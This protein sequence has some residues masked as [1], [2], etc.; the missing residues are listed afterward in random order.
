MSEPMSSTADTL[1]AQAL[2]LHR[3]GQVAQAQAL[4]Q[5]AL[6]AAP[7]H[8]EALHLL[9]VTW[10]QLGQPAQALPPLEAAVAAAPGHAK[11]LNNLG[12]A[13]R[14]QDRPAE[15]LA[16]FAAAAAAQPDFVDALH[17]QASTL[18]QL[19]RPAEALP[20]L[21][22]LLALAPADP[23]ALAQLGLALAATGQPAEALTALD[24]ALATQPDSPLLLQARA[25]ALV[26]LNRPAEAVVPLTRWIALE[27]EN[28]EAWH[29]R[30]LARAQAGQATLALGDFDRA[31][32]LQPAAARIH[33]NR[34]LACQALNRAE[35]ALAGFRRAAELQPDFAPAWDSMGAMLVN[36]GRTA[37]GLEC[38][39]RALLLAPESL[40]ALVNR[41]IALQRLDRWAE[42]EASY[43]T[44]LD[45]K[46]DHAEAL[47]GRGAMRDAAADPEAA[48]AD[49]R[50]AM[51][52]RPDYAEAEFYASLILLQQGDFAAGWPAYEA[53]RR[54]AFADP[55]LRRASPLWH[56][57]T[58]LV[59]R[60]ILL[61]DE[62]GLGDTFQFCRFAPLL[63]A[64][65]ARVLLEV[66]PP[67]VGVLRSLGP[68]VTVYGGGQIGQPHDLH[69]SL[70]SVPYA[71]GITPETVPAPIPYLHADPERVAHWARHIGT[72][73]LRIGICWQGS[74]GPL[75]MGRSIPL[76]EFLPLAQLPG[77]RLISL[78]KG[79][80]EAQLARLP[81]GM[82]VESL[83]ADFD[84]PGHAFRDTAAVMQVC[85][86]VITCDTAIGHL[87]GALGVPTWVVVKHV[88]D[89]RWISGR[90]D[91]PWYTTLRLFRQQRRD[92]WRSAFV[93]VEQAVQALLAGRAPRSPAGLH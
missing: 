5:Q 10:L 1:V 39:D 58:S 66:P 8:A 71:L 87:A 88:A 83:G 21:H 30:A 17:N 45:L 25:E 32:A 20:V 63:A 52:A 29:G 93:Q 79:S 27:G 11:A 15:A 75:A 74:T 60:T 41:G 80:G 7:G 13:L 44:A 37:E 51:A 81:A 78:H 54:T 48:L 33:H 91:S 47:C 72:E 26:D 16:R 59:G 86:L 77:V 70:L 67:M 34:A 90:D 35:E 23:G 82:R 69:C 38:H 31:L 28:A 73:G 22:A 85:D 49:F 2:P 84:P 6:A 42:A 64:Q 3:A 18:L 89:W 56:G 14:A 76:Q 92:D 65:G 9:G 36:L 57:Q 68:G 50:A 62:Q 24:Q 43:Q 55:K 12:A 19:D 61:H 46:P 40:Q 53:R 4:Y